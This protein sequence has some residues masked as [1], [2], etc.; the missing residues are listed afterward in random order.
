M[1]RQAKERLYPDDRRVVIVCGMRGENVHVEWCE[2]KDYPEA[3]EL[4][5]KRLEKQYGPGLAVG[6]RSTRKG[7]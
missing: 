1:I 6:K 3:I 7:S 5:Q 4:A 2:E